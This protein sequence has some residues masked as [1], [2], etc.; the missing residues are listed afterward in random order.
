MAIGIENKTNDWSEL[1][2]MNRTTD[3]TEMSSH[4]A[5]D[6]IYRLDVRR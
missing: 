4:G 5:R 2:M 6:G 1:T 3:Q